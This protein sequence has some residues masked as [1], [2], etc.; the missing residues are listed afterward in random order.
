MAKE[1]ILSLSGDLS[2]PEIV[3][4]L[5][6]EF[7]E[8]WDKTGSN[9]IIDMSEVTSIGYDAITTLLVLKNEKPQGSVSFRNIPDEIVRIIETF[10]IQV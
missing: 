10:R 7:Q 5:K 1:G 4:N 2:T 6:M 3:E 8:A 9:L